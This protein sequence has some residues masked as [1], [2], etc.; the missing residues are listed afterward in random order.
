MKLLVS[1]L[2]FLSLSVS[3]AMGQGLIRSVY[4]GAGSSCDQDGYYISYTIGQPAYMV[5][6]D[7]EGVITEGFQQPLPKNKPGFGIF[8]NVYPNPVFDILKIVISVKV[9]TD[10]I[11]EIFSVTGVRL[12]KTEITGLD[13]ALEYPFDFTGFP[14]GL[15]LLRVYSKSERNLDNLFKIEKL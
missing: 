11:L 8:V 14:Q 9:K 4:S 6:R 2:I 1:G 7:G 15:Y 12:S 13:T 10:M 3:L 5:Y